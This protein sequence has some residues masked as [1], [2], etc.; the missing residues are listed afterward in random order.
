M[1]RS[2]GAGLEQMDQT[3]GGAWRHR[4]G[5]A[6]AS[7]G[8]LAS[9]WTAP[10]VIGVSLTAGKEPRGRSTFH[11]VRRIASSFGESIT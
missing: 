4:F 11:Q 1:V 7:G 3:H 2:T 10:R 9:R 5:E 8:D 6:R